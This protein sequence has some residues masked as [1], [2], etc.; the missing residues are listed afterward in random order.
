MAALALGTQ[1]WYLGRDAAQ[2]QTVVFTTLCFMQLGHVLAIRSERSSLFTQG[3]WS[4]RPLA[5][6]VALTV[7]LQLAVVY[8]P[9]GNAWF[10]TAPLAPLDLAACVGA[11]L[12]IVAVV[13]AEKAVRRRQGATPA[14]AR[15]NSVA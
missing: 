4:N 3:L 12:V 13:E 1:A 5:L 14:S 2:W 11:A 7:L 15:G 10:R 8:T 9:L 6:A